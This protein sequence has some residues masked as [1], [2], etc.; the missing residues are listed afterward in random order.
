MPSSLLALPAVRL[1]A[2]VKRGE[3]SPVELLEACL[4]RLDATNAAV[5]ALVVR[6]YD[7]ARAEARAAAD[8]LAHLSPSDRAALP[9]LFGVPC[10]IK[11]FLAVTGMPW[12]AGLFSRR[13]A[14]A[15][16]DAT[17]VARVRAAGA[18][19]MGKS[20]VP[21]G[22]MWMETSNP[23]HGRTRNPWDLARTP[24]GSSGGEAAL[25]AAGGSP[26]GLGSDIAGSV[27]IPAAMCG[28]VGHKPSALLVPN[29]GHW[30]PENAASEAMLCTGPITRTVADAEHVLEV[31][32]GPD[33]E[34]GAVATLAPRDPA[35]AAGDLR[36]VRVVPVAR[37][38]RVRIAPVMAKAIER[39]TAAL[40]ARGAEVV[41]LDDATW[42][43]LFG[44]N[45]LA[46]LGAL[47]KTGEAPPGEPAQSFAE[48]LAGD[49]PL[50][51][52]PELVRA[53]RGRGRYSIPTLALVALERLGR[54]LE[55]V[56]LRG[57]P[58]IAALQAGLEEVIGPRGVLL[59]PPYSRP[60][61]RHHWPML[62]PFDAV[63]TSLFSITGLPATAVPVGFDEH[64]LPVGVQVVGRRGGDRLTLAAARVIEEACGGWH[65]AP[66]ATDGGA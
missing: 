22:G 41:D 55:S 5:N 12:T 44:G 54:P 27:R 47:A 24:G 66:L 58:P 49:E 18:I 14:I 8:T 42:H 13:D 1:A 48:L 62:T 11:D 6:R 39:A 19:V 63:C 57:T 37:H 33:G 36:G 50:R 20:N 38:G 25:V 23:L 45:V 59:H 34:S 40:V 3:L 61:P 65:P 16:H 28:C 21:E 51:V 43:R 10:T 4:T 26:F 7:A 60:A 31:I 9:P 2:L 17:V 46:W 52:V 64:E 29:T 53:A 35:L 15:D 32:A 56:L 30:G